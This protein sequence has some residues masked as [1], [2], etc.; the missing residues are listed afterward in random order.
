MTGEQTWPI[1]CATGHR[2]QHLH[3]ALHK[4]VQAQL[5]YVVRRLR[6]CHGTTTAISGM[7]LG[8]D[9]W[10]AWE[11]VVAG[12]DLWAYVPFPQQPAPWRP[13][14]RARW[15]WL[16]EHASRVKTFGR[17][18]DVRMLHA[19]NDGMLADSAAVVAVHRPGKVDGG[20][21]T[22]LRKARSR[23]MP[24]ILVDPDSRTVTWPAPPESGLF[25]LAVARGTC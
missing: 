16:I 5:G 17:D 14:D 24:V 23:R 21:A 11:A 8:V 1:V 2:P 18:V 20:T 4:W 10:W 9:Q 13:D 15:Q 6:D 19:R 3:P 22:T 25:P 12:L 7:A